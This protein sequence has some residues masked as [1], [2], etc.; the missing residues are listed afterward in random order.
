MEYGRGGKNGGLSSITSSRTDVFCEKV[1][2]EISQNS[3][4]NTCAR[5]SFLIKLQAPPENDI[6][7][8]SDGINFV[9]NRKSIRWDNSDFSKCQSHMKR[10]RT[11][12]F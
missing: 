3:Q 6:L 4:K 2:L 1:F 5:V 11:K 9:A 10:V 8:A 7:M 12:G